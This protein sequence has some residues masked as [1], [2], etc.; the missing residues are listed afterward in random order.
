MKV[1]QLANINNIRVAQSPGPRCNVILKA[2]SQQITDAFCNN[3][4]D[5]V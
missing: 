3:N 5:Q 2:W 4:T 1:S